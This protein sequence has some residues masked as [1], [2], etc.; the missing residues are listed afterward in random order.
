MANYGFSPNGGFINETNEQY[1]VGHQA[2]VADGSS[3]YKF[4]FDEV[5]TMAAAASPTTPTDWSSWNPSDPNF[6]LNN[7]DLMISTGGLDPYVLWDGT[8]GGIAGGP[9][10]FKVSQFSDTQDF[11]VIEFYDINTGLPANAVA[12]GYYIQVRLKSM[13]VDGAPN[14]GDYQ[15]ISIKDIVN[16]FLVGYVGEGNL[17]LYANRTD[18]MFHAKRRLQEFYYDT[19]PIIKSQEI[20]IPPTLS[21]IIPQDYVNHVQLS[22]VDDNGIKRIIYPTTLTSNPTETPLQDQNITQNSNYGF[23]FPSEGYGI[24]MQDQFGENLEGTSLTEERWENIPENL[25]KEWA[26]YG[27]VWSYRNFWGAYGKRYGTNPELMQVNG[28]YT[29]NKREGKFSFSSNLRGRLILLEYISDGLAYEED[30]KVPKLAEEALYMHIAHAVLASRM[31]VP[32]YIVQRYKK[33]RR[34]ALRNAKIRL[35][36]IKP[37][38]FVRIARGK[39]KWIKY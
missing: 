15:F 17:I 10:G 12:N 13:L 28:W 30:M 1:Y 24:P 33:D 21:V 34:A 37:N 32:E 29:I 18:I 22:W 25:E 2:K 26:Q 16:N 23:A 20:T 11:S 8:N 19:L 7:F 5:L 14:Y 27:S 9:Y 4:T 6:M 38:E 3:S 39:S 35:E 31:N 36:N